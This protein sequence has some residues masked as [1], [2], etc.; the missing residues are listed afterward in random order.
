[1]QEMDGAED[2]RSP[3]LRAGKMSTTNMIKG[4]KRWPWGRMGGTKAV[5]IVKG[6]TVEEAGITRSA[7]I[8]VAT[9]IH[10]VSWRG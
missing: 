5:K 10:A 1:M 4:T 9:K 8:K 7:W 6:A 3:S 2:Q